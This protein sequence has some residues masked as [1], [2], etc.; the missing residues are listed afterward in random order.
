MCHKYLIAKKGSRV[1]RYWPLT[2][3][4]NIMY[5]LKLNQFIFVTLKKFQQILTFQNNSF[6]D[7]SVYKNI[8]SKTWFRIRDSQDLIRCKTKDV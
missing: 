7:K 3:V 4:N 8:D 6:T 1:S 2:F 5:K